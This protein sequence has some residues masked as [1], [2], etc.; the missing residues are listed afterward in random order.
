MRLLVGAGA[1]PKAHTQDGMTLLMK[2]AQSTPNPVVEYA[3]M[4][5]DDVV[6]RTRNNRTVMY[7]AVM[8]SCNAPQ[9]KICDV[10]Q[11]LA[12]RGADP[13]PIDDCGRTKIS[14]A[15]G[16]PLEQVSRL[17]YKLTLAAGHQ[18]KILPKD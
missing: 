14:I 2:A 13:D 3:Y 8:Q 17:L 5:D 18:P 15:D 16:C 6:A 1:D 4:L 9:E 12:D 11:F 10:I 7:A